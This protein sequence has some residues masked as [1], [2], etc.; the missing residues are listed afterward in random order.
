M[1]LKYESIIGQR[2]LNKINER[3]RMRNGEMDRFLQVMNQKQFLK[4]KIIKKKR[5]KIYTHKQGDC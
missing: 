2:K 5:R 3:K 4:S 1:S